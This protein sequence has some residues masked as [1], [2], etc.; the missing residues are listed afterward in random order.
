MS[1]DLAPIPNQFVDASGLPRVGAKLFCYLAGTTTKQSTA[2]D[3]LGAASNTNPIILNASGSLPF[4]VWLTNGIAYDFVL[5]PSTDTD[6][7]TTTIWALDDVSGINDV[8]DTLFNQWVNTGFTP[9]YISATSFSI[10]GDQR[11]E[12]HAG[13]RIKATVTAGS[14]YGA[15]TVSTYS[16]SPDLTT[17]IVTLDNGSLDAGLSQ[18]DIGLLSTNNPS[19]PLNSAIPLVGGYVSWTIAANAL[20]VS[21]KTLSGND[22]SL[23]EPVY[24]LV[25]DTTQ[26]SRPIITRAIIAPLSMTVSSGSTLGTSSGI[27]SRIRAVLVDTGTNVVLGVYTAWSNPLK[28]LRIL[29]ESAV[30]STTAEGG[31][32]DADSSIIYTTAAQTSRPWVEIGYMESKQTTAGTWAQALD[33][34]VTISGNYKRA[35]DVVQLIPVLDLG[36]SSGTTQIP[37]DDTIPQITEGFELAGGVITATSPA[38]LLEIDSIMNFST[39]AAAHITQALFLDSGANAIAAKSIGVPTGNINLIYESYLKHY[40][41]ANSA[42]ALSFMLRTGPS[43]A[44]TVT[45][46]GFSAARKFGGVLVRYLIIKEIFV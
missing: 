37:I 13:R 26:A 44:A 28:V 7:P 34:Q 42:A 27:A 46:N 4:P 35:G 8:S 33:A 45:V 38:N 17:L 32:G 30:I 14:V 15:I 12:H 10:S 39:S 22:P 5:A 6:P 2:K 31:A 41:V 19:L 18:V 20:T 3:I 24:A 36:M 40:M 29:N 43:A 11:S 25:P 1:F 21:I 23:L 9:N 16:T